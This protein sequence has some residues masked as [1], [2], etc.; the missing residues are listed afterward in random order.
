MAQGEWSMRLDT[1]ILDELT[2]KMIEDHAQ[3]VTRMFLKG[4]APGRKG[5]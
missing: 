1:G 5:S 3:R 4:L 2:D